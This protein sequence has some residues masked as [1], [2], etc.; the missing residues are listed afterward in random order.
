M[1][2]IECALVGKL[3]KP[4]EQK[5]SKS[6]NPWCSVSLLV[7]EGD[8]GTWVRVAAFGEMADA[9]ARLDKGSSLYVEG[10]LSLQTWTAAVGVEK[11]GLN[12][13]ATRVEAL[14]QIGRRRVSD[15][16]A[17]RRPAAS[18]AKADYARPTETDARPAGRD[19]VRQDAIPF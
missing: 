12:V 2:G 15:D 7:G 9:V 1:N 16:N 11:S 13:T 14:G 4:G 17:H 8:A 18:A 3:M 10:R 5:K 19:P 6:G